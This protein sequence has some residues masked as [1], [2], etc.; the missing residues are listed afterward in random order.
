MLHAIWLGSVFG[1]FLLIRGLWMLICR[2]SVMKVESS[3]KSSPACFHMIAVIQLLLGLMIVNTCCMGPVQGS[4]LLV[5]I[6]GWALIIRAFLSFFVPKTVLKTVGNA[7]WNASMGVI[8]VIWGI[9][10]CWMSFYQ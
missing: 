5:A 6:L 8:T 3:I 7:K 10:M 4:A 1:P 2:S 9:A